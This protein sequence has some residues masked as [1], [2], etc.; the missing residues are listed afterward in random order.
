MYQPQHEIYMT[1]PDDVTVYQASCNEH[2]DFYLQDIDGSWWSCNCHGQPEK[3]ISEPTL[4]P[5]IFIAE[6]AINGNI[7]EA[8]SML[9]GM[10][11]SCL[12]GLHVLGVPENTLDAIKR[13]MCLETLES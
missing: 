8:A 10:S 6:Q 2:P 9:S 5:L 1:Q 4:D 13:R 3:E 7:K 11:P 12:D